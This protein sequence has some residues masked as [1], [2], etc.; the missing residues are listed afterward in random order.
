MTKTLE[1]LEKMMDDIEARSFET[2]FKPTLDDLTKE[3]FSVIYK[4]KADALYEV[5]VKL[6]SAREAKLLMKHRDFLFI[7]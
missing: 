7:W 2:H 5:G 4:A 6:L 1:L 3:E